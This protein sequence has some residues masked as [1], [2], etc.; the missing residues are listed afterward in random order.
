MVISAQV[1]GYS[2]TSFEWL[3]SS[4]ESTRLSREHIIESVDKQLLR[5]GT[6]YIDLLQFHWPDRN[7]HP[8]RFGEL[9]KYD[10]VRENEIPVQ[11]QLEAIAELL[12]SGKIRSFGVS[13]ETPFGLTNM[14]KIAEHLHL[15]RPVTLQMPLSLLE[16]QNELEMGLA[17]ACHPANLNVGVLAHTP[18]AGTV[19]VCSF[20][21]FNSYH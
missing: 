12:Q 4:K 20:V 17:E 13:N 11:E 19:T 8:P 1:C 21:L 15:P 7:L 16:G 9:F 14:V 3:R 2:P 18:L 5:L 10:R 6:D